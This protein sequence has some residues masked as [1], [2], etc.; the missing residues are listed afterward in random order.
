MLTASKFNNEEVK[1]IEANLKGSK[2]YF[3]LYFILFT[4]LSLILGLIGLAKKGFGYW[5]TA[6][7]FLISFLIITVYLF[8]KENILYKRDLKNKLKYTGTIMVLKKSRKRND[9]MIYTDAKEIKKI[10]VL[11]FNIFDQIEEG[12]YLDVE[13]ARSSKYVFKLNKGILALINGHN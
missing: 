12:D 7:G 2:I 10:D 11:F 13:I 9:C 6:L 8:I 4:P 3:V 1:T 5:P